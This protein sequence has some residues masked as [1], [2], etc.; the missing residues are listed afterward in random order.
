MAT[1]KPLEC[2]RGPREC[3][4]KLLEEASEACEALKELERS[5]SSLGCC[6]FS[7][8]TQEDY[9]RHR[10]LMELCDVLQVVTDCLHELGIAREEFEEF[11]ANVRQHNERRGRHE[12]DFAG[13]LVITWEVGS[14]D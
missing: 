6:D 10:A 5:R 7:G 12:L 3:G 11:V 4:L 2:M 13:E 14:D 8:K 1:L 9:A